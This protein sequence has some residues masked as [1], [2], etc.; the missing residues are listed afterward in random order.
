MALALL[1]CAEDQ[2]P[3]SVVDDRAGATAPDP[4]DDVK[5]PALLAARDPKPTARDD[6]GGS[7]GSAKDLVE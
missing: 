1:G 4:P 6:K 7:G 3:Q 5:I 2:A